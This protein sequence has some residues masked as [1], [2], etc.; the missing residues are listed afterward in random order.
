VTGVLIEKRGKEQ[1]IQAQSCLSCVFAFSWDSIWNFYDLYEHDTWDAGVSSS[2]KA[3]ALQSLA[4]AWNK[5]LV[6]PR[7]WLA[8]SGVFNWGCIWTL[9]DSGP[10]GA[11][12]HT[13][14][15]GFNIT[16]QR[17]SGY[18]YRIL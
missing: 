1:N 12:L 16:L 13:N 9:Q 5:F 17:F 2:W 8:G 14:A 15:K 6:C 3:T 11:E 7:H 4:T 18:L 10:P